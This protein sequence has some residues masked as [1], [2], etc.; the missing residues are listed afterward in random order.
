M[1]ENLKKYTVILGSKS[2][3]RQDLLRGIGVE[4]KILVKEID[5][6]FSPELKKQ[7]IPMFLSKEKAI[8]YDDELKDEKNLVITC[9]TIVWIND[10]ALNKPAD[11]KEAVEM[12]QSLSG[13]MHQVFTGVTLS[14][15]NKSVSFYEETNVFFKQLTDEEINYYIDNFKPYDKAGAYGVQEWMGFVGMRKI[16]GCFFNVMGLP[17]SKLYTELQKF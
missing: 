15:R 3:R 12:L 14:N 11:K 1:L 7:E 13:K 4:F 10:G 2:P 9:D 5:E 17:L 8:G 6:N 16:E